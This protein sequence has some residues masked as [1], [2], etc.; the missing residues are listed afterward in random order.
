MPKGYPDTVTCKNC[1]G[2]QPADYYFCPDCGERLPRPRW[3]TRKQP[4]KNVNFNGRN[5]LNE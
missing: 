4:T 3:E 1:D 2:G 5:K